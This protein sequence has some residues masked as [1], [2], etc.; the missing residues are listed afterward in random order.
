M[1]SRWLRGV[2]W[3]GILVVWAA[4]IALALA[5]L[6]AGLDKTFLFEPTGEARERDRVG[7]L[8]ILAGSAALFAAAVWARRM[9]TPIWACILVLSPVV[10]VGGLTLLFGNSLRPHLSALVAF[11][12][13]LAGLISGLILARPLLRVGAAHRSPAT[14]RQES[15]GSDPARRRRVART[16][17]PNPAASIAAKR[18]NPR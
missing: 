11:P 15:D 3:A 18:T 16:I 1:T 7:K 10:F 6:G 4:L 2:V 8:L 12:V 9:D 17:H 5:V 13:A 14:E